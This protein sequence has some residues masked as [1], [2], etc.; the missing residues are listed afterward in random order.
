M[1]LLALNGGLWGDFI[2]FCWISHYL[3]CPIYVWNKNNGCIIVKIQDENNGNTSH[4]VY[5]NN[6][7]EPT[8]TCYQTI[9]FFNCQN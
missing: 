4:I 2:V 9:V 3:Q 7:F 1:S 5:K 6:H 8:Y